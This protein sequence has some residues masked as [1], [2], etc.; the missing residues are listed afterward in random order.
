LIPQF[1]VKR[2]DVTETNICGGRKTVE[3]VSGSQSRLFAATGRGVN[4]KISLIIQ[5]VHPT[6]SRYKPKM[7]QLPIK[8]NG[9]IQS[10]RPAA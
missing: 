5:S 8:A 1:V 9:I 6:A 7:F 2:A 10:V 3:T 4:E